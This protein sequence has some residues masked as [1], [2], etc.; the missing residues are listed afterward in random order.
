MLIT[1]MDVATVLYVFYVP[2]PSK[3]VG[4]GGRGGSKLDFVENIKI[5]QFEYADHKNGCCNYS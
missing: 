5:S 1:K 3:R 4:K 2:S